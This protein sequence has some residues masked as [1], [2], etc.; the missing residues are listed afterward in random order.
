M[1]M[2]VCMNTVNT[3]SIQ[4]IYVSSQQNIYPSVTWN[5]LWQITYLN[6]K[7]FEVVLWF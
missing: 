1:D 5:N 7:A 6:I 3:Y 2:F 4:R